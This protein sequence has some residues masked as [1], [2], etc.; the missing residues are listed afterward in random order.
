MRFVLPGRPHTCLLNDNSLCSALFALPSSSIKNLIPSIFANQDPDFISGCTQGIL[1]VIGGGGSNPIGPA[2]ANKPRSYA[3]ARLALNPQVL[4]REHRTTFA[5]GFRLP[6]KFLVNECS[7]AVFRYVRNCAFSR[8][9]VNIYASPCLSE[10][11]Q[12]GFCENCTTFL[13][14]PTGGLVCFFPWR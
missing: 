1:P 3:V 2:H 8:L 14:P 4:R 13:S 12:D 6:K 11:L 9:A 7:R 5:S 10:V